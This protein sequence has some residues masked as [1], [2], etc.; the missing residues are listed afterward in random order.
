MDRPFGIDCKVKECCMLRLN[1][2]LF[3]ARLL[4]LTIQNQRSQSV[5]LFED[6]TYV[7][8]HEGRRSCSSGQLLGSS[9]GKKCIKS[10][11]G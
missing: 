7:G 3:F 8:A 9:A 1:V 2:L 4:V 6:P 5:K 11:M 10:S